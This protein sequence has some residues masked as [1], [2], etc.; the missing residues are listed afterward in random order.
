MGG[1]HV[2]VEQMSLAHRDRTDDRI[3]IPPAG[4]TSPSPSTCGPCSNCK[5][6]L[7]GVLEYFG[8]TSRCDIQYGGLVELILN[9]MVDVPK[10][11][12]EWQQEV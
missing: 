10:P 7:K 11:F 3:R 4:L 6:Q 5:G 12:M 8:A 1:Q 9:A 2:V